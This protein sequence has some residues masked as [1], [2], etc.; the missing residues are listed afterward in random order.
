MAIM[1]QSASGVGPHSLSRQPADISEPKPDHT[2]TLRALASVAPELLAEHTTSENNQENAKKIR[3]LLLSGALHHEAKANAIAKRAESG[4]R[5]HAIFRPMGAM[6]DA[7]E[8]G[9]L[10]TL[11]RLIA[12]GGDVNALGEN[13]NS[14]LA[15]ACA[16]GHADCTSLLISNGAT[17]DLRSNLGN[18][19][20]H[21]ACW[22]DSP[23][24]IRILIDAKA[25]VN[26][27][28]STN[29]AT[30]MHVAV[31]GN[32]DEA[33]LLLLSRGGD[34]K[35]KC[36]GRTALQLS[37]TLEHK[38]CE[39][40]LRKFDADEQA[41]ERRIAEVQRVE[42]EKK[43]NAAADLL[44]AELEA[45][46]EAKGGG[47]AGGG[48]AAASGKKASKKQRQKEPRCIMKSSVFTTDPPQKTR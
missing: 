9:D 7:A 24:C 36:D 17:V 22:A 31:Q 39:R 40:V 34:R 14:A 46:E 42:A 1:M 13:G 37:V 10:A 41:K 44:L 38:E 8:Q 32:R 19:P 45:E 2:E 26:L 16:N 21:A 12:M 28:S 48:S 47:K 18:S 4:G 27:R 35:M 15:F 6:C 29:G 11:T 3:H 23:K 5:G 43:A 30:P 20:L 25:E 33:L